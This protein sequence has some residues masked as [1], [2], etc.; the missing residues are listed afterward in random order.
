MAYSFAYC[1]EYSLLIQ[2][3]G[4]ETYH[5]SFA[6]VATFWRTTPRNDLISRPVKLHIAPRI[7]KPSGHDTVPVLLGRR[8]VNTLWLRRRAWP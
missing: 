1:R 8:A 2:D 6:I 7:S 5:V 4:E 3:N